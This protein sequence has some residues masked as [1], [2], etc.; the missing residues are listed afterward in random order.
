VRGDAMEGVE[1]HKL[2]ATAEMR[3]LSNRICGA[4]VPATHSAIILCPTLCQ[5]ALPDG[6]ESDHA[7]F[8]AGS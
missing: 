3:Y 1:D 5:A 4:A 8:R 7:S 2:Q 6:F